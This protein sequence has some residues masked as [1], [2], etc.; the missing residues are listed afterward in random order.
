MAT[1]ITLAEVTPYRLTYLVT[2]TST[3]GGSESGFIPNAPLA[4]FGTPDLQIDAG[5][6]K[7]SA[8]HNLVRT[9]V[10]TNNQA[11]RVLNGDGLITPVSV[12]IARAHI[13]LTPLNTLL[14][15]FTAWSV[16][17]AEGSTVDPASTGFPVV[18][19]TGPGAVGAAALIDIDFQHTYDR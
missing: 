11:Q 3:E 5:T 7:G 16:D 17:A 1:T 18:I 10:T 2:V 14:A 9:N 19:F 13:K 6:F 4:V 15:S 8:L 12:E